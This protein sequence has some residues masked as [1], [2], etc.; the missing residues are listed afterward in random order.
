MEVSFKPVD[1]PSPCRKHLKRLWKGQR[2]FIPERF[3]KP[4]SAVSVVSKTHIQSRGKCF[5]DK[6]SEA[7]SDISFRV[8]THLPEI[9]IIFPTYWKQHG[10]NCAGIRVCA[11]ECVSFKCEENLTTQTDRHVCVNVVLRLFY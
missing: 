6:H 1:T 5:K 3:H 4:S 8:V 11:H 2:G 10:N 7:S 9:I